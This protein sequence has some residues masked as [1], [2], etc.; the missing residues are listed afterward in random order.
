MGRVGVLGLK[1]KVDRAWSEDFEDWLS[2]MSRS[3]SMAIERE[4]L[5]EK[6]AADDLARESERLG[7]L[8]LDSVSHELRTP[9]AVIEG[10]ASAL[11]SSDRDAGA[12]LGETGRREL[13]TEIAT[14]AARLDGV[15]EVLLSMGR[16]ESPTCASRSTPPPNRA[17]CAA[18]RA[19]SCRF[20]S[21][22]SETAGATPGPRPRSPS[23]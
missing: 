4:R 9:L 21:T 15:V 17:P 11:V 7:A 14:S 12:A 23:K 3:L 19:S 22:S 10:T 5:A 13:V 6:A 18:T 16:L 1:P 8:L 2:T 20:S